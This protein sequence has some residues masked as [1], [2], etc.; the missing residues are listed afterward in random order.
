MKY[1]I[2]IVEDEK[3]L[4]DRMEYLLLKE[5]KED[6]DI[7]VAYGADA[8][9]SKRR[10]DIAIVDLNM[11]YLDSD[12]HELDENAGEYVINNLVNCNPDIFI[13]VRTSVSRIETV[14]RA[15][16]AAERG[17]FKFIPKTI[18]EDYRILINEV[19]CQI[20]HIKEKY[21]IR[22]DYGNLTYIHKNDDIV[23]WRSFKHDDVYVN[24][25]LVKLPAGGQKAALYKHLINKGQWLYDK[26]VLRSAGYEVEKLDDETISKYYKDNIKGK[27]KFLKDSDLILQSNWER[28]HRI[29]LKTRKDE[30]K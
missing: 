19:I 9:I 7:T 24:G 25:Q 23:D 3:S 14:A 11:P 1:H 8:E 2:L 12:F 21:P 6:L 17:A 16:N 18:H 30:Y 26:V 4:A 28:Q 10:F 27:L 13:I 15:S 5:V 22:I 29:I 20:Q